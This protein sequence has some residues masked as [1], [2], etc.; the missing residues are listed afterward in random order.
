MM[1]KS[2]GN[3]AAVKELERATVTV[4]FLGR[5]DTALR[6]RYPQAFI[7][8]ADAVMRFVVVV[9]LHPGL[10]VAVQFLQG[11]YVFELYLFQETVHRR[12]EAFH[13]T[14]APGVIGLCVH[15]PYAQTL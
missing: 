10:P 11:L 13:Q 8:F 15:V 2:F 3:N 7:V 9:F 5:C 1:Q 6:D 4:P 12:I 14:L